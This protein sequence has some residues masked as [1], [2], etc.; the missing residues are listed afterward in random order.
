MLNLDNSLS[1]KMIGRNYV[2]R[3]PYEEL[4]FRRVLVRRYKHKGSLEYP[5]GQSQKKISG[6]C[7][8]AGCNNQEIWA[9]IPHKR[10]KLY[11]EVPGCGSRWMQMY[12]MLRVLTPDIRLLLTLGYRLSLPNRKGLIK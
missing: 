1:C 2:L 11:L 8:F 12:T 6:A 5:A 3:W 4:L 9:V 10:G 7:V